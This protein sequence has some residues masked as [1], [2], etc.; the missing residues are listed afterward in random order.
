MNY[1]EIEKEL[2]NAAS[3]PGIVACA[4]VA[5]DTGMIYLS[6]SHE[7]KFEVMAE[8]ARDY[9]RLHIKNSDIFMHMGKI[10]NIFIQHQ[11][12]MVS[13]QPCGNT[14]ILVTQAQ[15]GQVDWNTWPKRIGPL[16]AL[17]KGFENTS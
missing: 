5:I 9:W 7:K 10:N 8:C 14:M 4:I 6:T 2:V 13:I 17:I 16:K 1:Q 3:T 12:N 11:H 15:L